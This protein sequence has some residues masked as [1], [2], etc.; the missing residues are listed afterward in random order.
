MIRFHTTLVVFSALAVGG[1]GA[2]PNKS[3]YD[4]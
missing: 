3:H 4:A 1:C 2:Q